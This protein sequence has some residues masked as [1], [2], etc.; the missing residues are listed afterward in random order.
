M[1]EIKYRAY[2]KH[3]QIIIE[4]Q[5]INFDCKTVEW[6]IVHPDEWDMSEFSFD[7]VELMQYTWLKDKNGKE[8][9]EWDVALIFWI[10]AKVRY[11]DTW[12]WW[13]FFC[14][15]KPKELQELPFYDW[16]NG[17]Y[18]ECEIIGNIYEQWNQ[19]N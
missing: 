16:E 6:Y 17:N 18:K 9:W 5:R 15:Q 19:S 12:C 10:T 4:V 14:R 7:E 11:S 2:V 3:L 13:V 8:I 1:R